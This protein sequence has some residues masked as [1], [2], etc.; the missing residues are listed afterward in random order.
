ML[1][2]QSSGG[3]FEINEHNIQVFIVRAVAENF[4]RRG[5]LTF[6]NLKTDL[7]RLE[8]S[9]MHHLHRINASNSN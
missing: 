5:A 2:Y 1:A 8:S 7:I 4:S 3:A 9:S 6:P